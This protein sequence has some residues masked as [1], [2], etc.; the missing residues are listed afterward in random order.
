MGNI[1]PDPSC[2]VETPRPSAK[3]QGMRFL[4]ATMLICVAVLA[5]VSFIA[6]SAPSWEISADSGP[7]SDWQA[8]VLY[9]KPSGSRI[10]WRLA[11]WCPLS[12][13]VTLCAVA[14]VR[15]LPM[16]EMHFKVRMWLGLPLLTCSA[17]L[18]HYTFTDNAIFSMYDTLWIRYGY[19]V[20]AGA[21]AGA[22]IAIAI[23]PRRWHVGLAITIL[24]AFAGNVACALIQFPGV[25][26]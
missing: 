12:L 16:R 1:I 24:G 22:A 2:K 10:A 4:L 7:S 20:A 18:V 19:W 26:E 6:V 3:M 23:W 17:L 15:S 11:I 13:G 5:V 21:A 9:L 25:R 8:G 14:I